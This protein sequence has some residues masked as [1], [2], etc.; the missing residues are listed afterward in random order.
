MTQ[1]VAVAPGEELLHMRQPANAEHGAMASLPAAGIAEAQRAFF[2][3][4]LARDIGFRI[5][6]LGVLRSAVVQ[7][8]DT[9]CRR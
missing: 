6:Q 5:R 3:R 1:A 2:R 4:G 8:E 9:F 7:R